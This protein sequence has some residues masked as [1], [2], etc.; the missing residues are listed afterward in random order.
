VS[1][2]ARTAIDYIDQEKLTA[3]KALAGAG[4]VLFTDE[5]LLDEAKR[6]FHAMTGGKKYESALP[7]DLKP[8]FNQFSSPHR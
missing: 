3:A 8:A 6:K 2:R 1:V 5:A 7:K 4:Y